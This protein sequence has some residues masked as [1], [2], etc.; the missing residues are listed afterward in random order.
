MESDPLA[1][2]TMAEELLRIRGKDWAGAAFM[3]Q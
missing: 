3:R 2:M 1:T